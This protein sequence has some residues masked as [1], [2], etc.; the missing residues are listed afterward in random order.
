MHLNAVLIMS[1]SIM[2]WCRSSL[3]SFRAPST[4]SSSVS[5]PLPSSS[6]R[7]KTFW[8]NFLSFSWFRSLEKAYRA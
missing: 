6:M 4:S 2:A 7:S 5:S 8:R 3:L 1:N